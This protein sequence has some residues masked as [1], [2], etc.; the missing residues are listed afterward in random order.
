M[1]QII[2]L[3]RDWEFTERFSEGF[4]VGIGSYEKVRLPHTVKQ[5]PYDYFDEQ[6]YQMICG[7]R[8]PVTLPE[9][10]EGKRVFLIIEAAAHCAK[11]YVDG[12]L[13]NTH[14]GGYT[15]F[16][17]ELS[18]VLSDD[19]TCM[20]CIEVDTRESQNIPPFGNMIDYM[21]YGGLYREVR[22]EI[23]SEKHISDVFARPSVPLKA[24]KTDKP[25]NEIVFGGTV[26][27][28]VIIDGAG[29]FEIR[30]TV[31]P[32]NEFDR[33]LVSRSFLKSDHMRL[34]LP[35]AR[36]WD[37][38]SP[39][40]YTLRTE[41]IEEGVFIDRVDTTIGFRRS[42]FCADGYYLNGRR[43]K[44]VGLNRHQSFPYV[45][46]AMPRSM[47][48]YDA[49][50]LKNELGVNAVRT[51][52]YPQSQHFID[53][54]DELGLLVFTE[55]P[56]WQ[57]VG[58]EEWKDIAVRHTREM[59]TR[60]RNHPSVILWGVRINESRDDD[61]FYARTNAAA[62]V[63]DPTRP[64]GGVRCYKKGSLLEDVYTYNDFIHNGTNEGCD[65]KYAVTPD[66]NK[67]YMITEFNG[68]M[69][70][71]KSYDSE[72]HRLEH[73]LRHARVIDSVYGY[74]DICGCF[75]WCFFDYNTHRD[76]GSGD[77]VC[78]HGV[79]DMFR[80]KKLAAEVYAARKDN[81][82]VLAISSSMDIGEHPAS[83]RG[84]VYA[85]TN[86]DSVRL[87]QNDS[88]IRE[89]TH[90]DSPFK[91]M[92]RPPIG[93]DDFIGERIAEQEDFA[94]RQAQYVKDILNEAAR[95]GMENLSL[96][97]K[98]KAAQLM[99]RYQMSFE[100]A[101]ALYGKYISNWG[102]SAAVFRFD[103]VKDG[104]VVESVTK[105]PF[106]ERILRADVDHTALH[107][108]ATYDVAAI[109]LRMTD[110]HGN[111]LSFCFEPVSV[112]LSGAAEVYGEAPVLRGGMGGLYIRTTGEP[113]EAT[114]T[115]RAQ[116]APAVTIHFTIT[117]G[118]G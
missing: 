9:S 117:S 25:I 115:L 94:P 18:G 1:R 41:L 11:V 113:G 24:L 35:G 43:L 31:F 100:D 30:Q 98:R 91:N 29:E 105:A 87:Y 89:Y 47:Q 84:Q 102:D 8:M 10:A 62:H 13:M 27:S 7:Y 55:I 70:P 64:T 88:F 6:C 116:N 106:T 92:P 93:I 90:A 75:G 86:A 5:T 34:T 61:D 69:F 95:D 51:S 58:D 110:E 68:H 118:E 99:L 12:A 107:E 81:E 26:E 60:Y 83:V 82:P 67:P 16:E 108:G 103:A 15:A 104:Q 20:L 50:L 72:D 49:E 114:L 17:T 36:L 23:R 65:S 2:H 76:F 52:H 37:V 85:F 39:T 97:A 54:C 32:Y 19:R 63:L 4:A 42:E 3:N 71:T 109:R 22:L 56:G 44:I 112:E 66:M 77:R 80:N 59:V 111:T 45:G 96:S 21:T 57:Y 14:K 48:R 101:Y 28:D 46:Y 73:A 33:P 53:R 78:Y 74:E 79:C 40:L 38:E